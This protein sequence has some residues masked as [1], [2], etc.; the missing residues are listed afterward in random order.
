MSSELCCPVSHWWSVLCWTSNGSHVK[1]SFPDTVKK[2]EH[3]IHLLYLDQTTFQKLS[4]HCFIFTC[5]EL[6][7]LQTTSFP[8]LVLGDDALWWFWR[9]PQRCPVTVVDEPHRSEAW[10]PLI[11]VRSAVC[12]PR[13]APAAGQQEGWCRLLS[14]TRPGAGEEGLA[15]KLP[16]AL[17]N[18]FCP[19]KSE[20]EKHWS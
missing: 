20:C 1:C 3:G 5:Y 14:K 9:W 11:L 12:E 7:C 13:G 6:G 17:G 18:A 16:P 10:L 4:S 2:S 15:V 19:F 8:G